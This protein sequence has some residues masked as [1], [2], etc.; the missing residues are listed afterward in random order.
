MLEILGQH[1]IRKNNYTLQEDKEDCL[2]LSY[3]TIFTK[4]TS[5]NPDK[6]INAFA[7]FSEVH[8]RATAEMLNK[9]Y[10]KK[11]ISEKQQKYVKTLSI[12]STN[13]GNGLYNI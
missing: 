12:N 7:Y 9:I 10:F 11:G 13:N 2:Q 8:K 6:T 3:L 1:A 4:W 5:F